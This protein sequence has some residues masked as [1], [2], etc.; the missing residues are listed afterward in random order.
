MKVTP[1]TLAEC[2]GLALRTE[3]ESRGWSQGEMAK[4]LGFTTQSALSHWETGKVG[5][6]PLKLWLL[7]ISVDAIF[8]RAQAL[9]LQS[10]VPLPTPPVPR[11][12]TWGDGG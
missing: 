5:I 7:G 8:R 10:G 11:G 3:R 12:G 2:V 9:A 1:E 4:R 6:D